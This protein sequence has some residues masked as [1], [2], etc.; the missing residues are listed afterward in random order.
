MLFQNNERNDLQRIPYARAG[1]YFYINE[2]Y[3]LRSL[4]LIFVYANDMMHTGDIAFGISVLNNGESERYNYFGDEGS[5]CLVTSSNRYMEVALTDY[6]QVRFRCS[7]GAGFQLSLSAMNGDSPAIALK[8]AVILE[9]GTCELY[10]GNF[11]YMRFEPLCGEF[12]INCIWDTDMSRYESFEIIFLPDSNGDCETVLHDYRGQFQRC[13]G[14]LPFDEVVCNNKKD[15]ADFKKRYHIVTG[16]YEI[17]AEECMYEVWSH[18][19]KADGFAHTPLIMFQYICLS[20]AFA[21]QQ[22]FNGMAMLADPMV[23]FK[24]ITNMFEYQ[25]SKS[26]LLPA[27]I[28]SGY[29]NYAGAQPPLQGFAMNLLFKL[30]G[31]EYVS[32]DMALK[33]LPKFKRWI[34]YWTTY[35]TAG[36]GDDV[37][38]INN[39]NESGWD[40]ASIFVKGFPAANADTLALLTE[41][42]YA[43]SKIAFL[44]GNPDEGEHWKKRGDALL[45]TIVTE[46]W[47]GKKFLTEVNGIKYAT[48]SFAAYQPLLLGDKLPPEIVDRCIEGIFEKGT[49]M[50]PI[51]ICSESMKSKLCTWGGAHFVLGRVVAPVQLFICIGLWLAGRKKEA[52]VIAEAWCENVAKK[53]VRLGFKPFEIMPLTGKPAVAIIEPQPSDSWAWSS[54]SACCTLTILQIILSD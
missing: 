44:A 41:C 39:P 53:G 46:F 30:C 17:L 4:Q 32:S 51:G 2:D 27:T 49:F 45:N 48:E 20:A 26:G 14:Y 22:S 52:R 25:E 8:S 5:L 11:G 13:K 9:D 31:E 16:K 40:D 3:F 18:Y 12:E 7:K 35:R 19:M 28:N 37:I 6:N 47:D 24:F 34:E 15:F 33:L 38:Q 29:I 42:M 21:W 23:G 10:F 50:T 1:S 43:C 54:W 36:R